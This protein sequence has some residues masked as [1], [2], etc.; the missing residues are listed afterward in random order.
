MKSTII[1]VVVSVAI[2]LGFIVVVQNNTSSSVIEPQS[3][4]ISTEG[5]QIVEIRAK[6]GYMPRVTT[7]KAGIPTIIQVKTEGTF[8]CSASLTVPAVGFSKHLPASGV[9]SIEIPAQSANA[10]VQGICSM[11]MYSFTVNF[12]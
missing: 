9:T 2:I 3:T 1:T 5:K 12:V 8:D 10:V 7:A 6:G 11:G 4:A